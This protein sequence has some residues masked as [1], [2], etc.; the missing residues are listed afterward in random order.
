MI[1][2]INYGGLKTE[3][4]KMFDAECEMI[5][6]YVQ[7]YSY[8][9]FRKWVESLAMAEDTDLWIL[10]SDVDQ[11]LKFDQHGLVYLVTKYGVN[12]NTVETGPNGGSW[13]GSVLFDEKT[14]KRFLDL[15]AHLDE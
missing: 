3:V 6:N 8:S 15:M 12:I 11:Q 2:A 9:K 10:T 14:G 4:K 5:K 13:G 7:N 1:N